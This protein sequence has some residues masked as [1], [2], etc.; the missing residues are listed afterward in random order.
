MNEV[1]RVE[2]ASSLPPEWDGLA[3]HYFQRRGF[4]AH[5]ERFNPCGQRYYLALRDGRAAAGA[6]VYS[7]RINPFT[8]VGLPGALGVAIVGIPCSVSSAGMVGSR[9]DVAWLAGRIPDFER[10]LVIGLNLDAPLDCPRLVCG[11]T[12]PSIRLGLPFR[13]WEEYR[14]AMRSRYRRRLDRQ[15][16][17]W[18]DVVSERGPC[19]RMDASMHGQYLEVFRHS[20]AALE[21]LS[22]EFLRNLPAAFALTAHRAG[23]RV[24]GWHIVLDEGAHRTF[25]L[26]G[27]D[28]ST[29]AERGNY[30]NLLARLVREAIEDG[31]WEIDLGQTAEVAKTRLGGQVVEKS[32]FGTSSA[33]AMRSLL[34]LGRPLLEYRGRVPAAHVFRGA[35][36]PSA[37]SE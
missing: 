13:T 37:A 17:R 21:C 1:R 22:L 28:Y 27:I 18:R 9:E 23:D 30:H 16:A 11:R 25:F 3:A 8:F 10:G 5:A 32:L 15:L 12:L 35:A 14:A 31:A 34:R 24:L 33:G 7:L 26:A 4:L 36:Q 2:R 19:G 6:C 20:G 29:L